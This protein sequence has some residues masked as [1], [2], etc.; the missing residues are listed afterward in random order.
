MGYKIV[1]PQTKKARHNWRAFKV[2]RG[3]GGSRT[4]VQTFGNK[5]FYILSLLIDCRVE[6]G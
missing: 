2:V 6:L 1:F 5:A 4:L 3:S